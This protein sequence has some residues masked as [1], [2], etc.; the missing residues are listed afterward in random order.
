MQ[1]L[2]PIF[3]TV[4]SCTDVASVVYPQILDLSLFLPHFLFKILI[5]KASYHSFY[6]LESYIKISKK[7]NRL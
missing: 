2:L 3:E 5:S 4:L 7:K 6:Q 1:S